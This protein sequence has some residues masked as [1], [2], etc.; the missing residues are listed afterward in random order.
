[1]QAMPGYDFGRVPD[2]PISDEEFELLKRAVMLT[3]EDFKYL[4]MACDILKDQIDAILDLWYGWVGSNP[5]L[6]Y[7]FG[8]KAGRPIPEYLDAVRK[9]FGQWILDT[10]CR[11]YDREW[12]NYMYEVGLRHHKSKK[13]KTDKVDTVEHVPLRYIVAFI[14][15]IGLTIRPFLA[16]K[17]HSA[18]D[19]ERMWSA[20]LKSVVLQVAIWARPY[21]KEGEW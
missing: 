14:A 11:D 8:D 2:A 10:T 4:K 16:K 20:W 1:M 21:S 5:H 7:Y 9:R 19:V 12:L 17:G 3:D 15:P 6:V 18:E 13:G